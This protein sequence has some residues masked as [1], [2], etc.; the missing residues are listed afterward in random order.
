MSNSLFRKKG[1]TD[2]AARHVNSMLNTAAWKSLGC[3][4]RCVYIEI[5]KR[6]G[7]LGT[8]NGRIHYS[9]R[10]GAA[11]LAVSKTSIAKALRELQDRGFIVAVTREDL[12]EKTDMRR[13]GDSRHMPAMYPRT[14]RPENLNGGSLAERSASLRRSKTRS[15]QADLTSLPADSTVLLGGQ[16]FRKVGQNTL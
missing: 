16:W 9:V 4:A 2:K 12:I 13:N 10:E 14:L 11:A 6:Y 3:T 8:N 1:R 5:E 15:L 7:G